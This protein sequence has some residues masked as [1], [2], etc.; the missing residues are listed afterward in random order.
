MKTNVSHGE[1]AKAVFDQQKA[2]RQRVEENGGVDNEVRPARLRATVFRGALCAP[3]GAP[4]RCQLTAAALQATRVAAATAHTLFVASGAQVFSA[5]LPY[6]LP[7]G[8][9]ESWQQLDTPTLVPSTMP[10]DGVACVALPAF[11]TVLVQ[12]GS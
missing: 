9:E 1:R 6:A 7:G 10:G 2:K 12:L 3:D 4:R 8:G 11:A 5:Q